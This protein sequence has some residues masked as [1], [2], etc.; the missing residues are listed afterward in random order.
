MLALPLGFT[1]ALAALGLLPAARAQPI[2]QGSI[3][4]AAVV[5]LGWNAALLLSGRGR[6]ALGVSFVLR[7]PHWLQPIVQLSIYVYWGMRWHQVAESAWMIF[8]QLLFAYAFDMLLSWSR[9]ETYQLGFGPCP[10][11]LS[12]NLFLWFKPEWFYLQFLMVAVGFGVKELI[13]WRK[14]GAP[15]HIFNPSSFPLAI[16]SVFLIL[17]NSSDLTFG[18]EIAIS[19]ERPRSIYEM[20]FLIS[21]PGQFLFGVAS[22]TLPAMF[23]T[24]SCSAIYFLITGTYY[25]FG[26]VPVAVFLDAPPVH[27]P[28]DSAADRA[29]AHPLRPALRDERL[30][31]LRAA[32]SRRPADLLRQAPRGAAPQSERSRD[33]PVGDLPR[34]TPIRSRPAGDPTRRASPAPRLHGRMDPGILRNSPGARRGR[35][36]PRESTAVLAA[37]LRPAPP[38][39]LPQPRNDGVEVLRARIGLGLQ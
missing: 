17:T 38:Q 34:R 1:I 18:N 27:R 10:I 14:D 4:G 32:R 20:L 15:A 28:L 37:G 11:I 30:H 26:P 31:S 33:R 7:R 23:A 22:M 5:L 19:L 9:R 25:F 39:R 8:A 29:R 36:S 6:R 12:M 2:L 21:L 13:R 3:F 16:V 24:F 35:P